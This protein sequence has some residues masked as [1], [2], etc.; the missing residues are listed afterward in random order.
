VNLTGTQ[1]LVAVFDDDWESGIWHK[2]MKT[3][4]AQSASEEMQ[5]GN[6]LLSKPNL[7]PIEFNRELTP[8]HAQERSAHGYRQN[9]WKSM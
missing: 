9:W 1:C 2:L 4:R 6:Q 3:N 7:Q 5:R 8:I